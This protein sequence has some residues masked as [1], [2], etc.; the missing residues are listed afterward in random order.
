MKSS[1]ITKISQQCIASF[2]MMVMVFSPV[3]VSAQVAGVSVRP[4]TLSDVF[5][6]TIDDTFDDLEYYVDG[7]IN[8]GLGELGT[9]NVIVDGAIQGVAGVAAG[10]LSCLA[11]AALTGVAAGIVGVVVPTNDAATTLNT[12]GNFTKECMLDQ[13]GFQLKEALI[14]GILRGMVVYINNGFSHGP[15]YLQNERTFFESQRDQQ[16]EEFI[17]NPDNFSSLCSAW[18]ADVRLSLATQY[19]TAV[20]GRQVTQ[21]SGTGTGTDSPVA[22]SDGPASCSVQEEG[23]ASNDPNTQDGDYWGDFLARTTTTGGNAVNSYFSLERQFQ[24]NLQYN[25]ESKMRELERNGGFFDVT[26]CDDGT[27]AYSEMPGTTVDTGNQNCKVTTPGT[28]INHQLNEALGSDLRRLEL[29]DEF[30]EVFTALIGQLINMIFSELGLFGTTQSTGGSQSLIDDYAESTNG[31]ATIASRDELL[32]ELNEYQEYA[33]EHITFKQRS[34]TALFD[35]RE[36]IFDAMTC[37]QSK[38]N[39]WIFTPDWTIIH[40]DELDSVAVEDRERATFFTTFQIGTNMDGEPVTTTVY[41]TPTESQSQYE[42]YFGLL[43]EIN[44]YIISLQDQINFTELQIDEAEILKI[45]MGY[46][47]ASSTDPLSAALASSTILERISEEFVGTANTVQVALDDGT[48][49]EIP[50]NLSAEQLLEIYIVALEELTVFDNQ[51]ALEQAERM[52]SAV[53]D[54]LEGVTLTNGER[55]P[56]VLADVQKCAAFTNVFNP[57]GVGDGPDP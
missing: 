17:N 37:Y 10:A 33:E 7:Q 36:A 3:L 35:A 8:G 56:G 12:G 4:G 31:A 14:K 16:F 13:I 6:D 26:Y 30:D 51:A 24:R 29:A 34:L 44:S 52:E 25:V 11:G 53:T 40:P 28:V 23:Y 27:D 32:R 48:F 45:Q 50:Q 18:E 5:T 22:G 46:L 57:T 55:A 15:G 42:A 54:M 39:T 38:Y 41:L 43:E 9:G 47:N 49:V 1:M 19:S 20:A 21:I 2:V